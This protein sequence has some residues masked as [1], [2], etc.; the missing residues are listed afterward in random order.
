M[1]MPTT[2]SC[3]VLFTW[4]FVQKMHVASCFLLA[5]C[6]YLLLTQSGQREAELYLSYKNNTAS[7]LNGLHSFDPQVM[8]ESQSF[9][10]LF[11][12]V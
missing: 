10:L 5:L 2:R 4:S 6:E 12:E 3:S 11:H 1:C 7:D 9:R 8:L